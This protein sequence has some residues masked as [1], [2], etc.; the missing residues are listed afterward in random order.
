MKTLLKDARIRAEIVIVPTGNQREAVREAMGDSAILFAGF[1]LPENELPDK[2][3]AR[4]H[5]VMSLPGEIVLVRCSGNLSL[6]A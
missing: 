1:D 4:M 2:A 6:S 5:E 3:F